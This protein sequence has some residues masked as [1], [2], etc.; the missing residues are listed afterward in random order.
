MPQ[1]E[2]A[3]LAVKRIML[4]YRKTRSP[5]GAGLRPGIDRT[6]DDS[7]FEITYEDPENLEHP[8]NLV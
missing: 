7:G 8:E 3:A 2:G 5:C 6:V 1:A 4:D